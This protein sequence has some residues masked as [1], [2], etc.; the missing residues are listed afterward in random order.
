VGCFNY[1]L[2]LAI[3][4]LIA[5]KSWMAAMAVGSERELKADIRLTFYS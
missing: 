3:S 5:M 4:K 1:F 2:D